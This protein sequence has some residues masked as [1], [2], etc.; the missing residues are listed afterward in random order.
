VN[1]SGP[2]VQT[3]R[4]GLGKQQGGIVT[5]PGPVII[6]TQD[7]YVDK[8]GP[9]PPIVRKATKNELD[10]NLRNM[11]AETEAKIA[12]L[13]MENNRIKWR[14]EQVEREIKTINGGRALQS[15]SVTPNTNVR[16]ERAGPSQNY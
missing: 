13:I 1:G 6:E 4:I 5:I 10:V 14:T 7:V 9:A 3:D 12:L 16:V 15:P 11:I 2:K 8:Y